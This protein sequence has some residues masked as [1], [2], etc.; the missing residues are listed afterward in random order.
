MLRTRARADRDGIAPAVRAAA[1][2]AATD[3]VDRALAALPTGAVV[4]LY[5][6]IRSE[7]AT[8]AIA[9]AAIARGLVLAYPRV[10]DGDRHLV[11]HRAAAADLAPGHFRI[12]EPDPGA[13][14]VDAAALAAIVVPALL[15][16]RR[17]HRLGWGRGYYDATLPMAP[18]ALR[19]GLGFEQQLV[20]RLPIHAHDCPV[21][22][23]ATEVALHPGAPLGVARKGPTT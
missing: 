21:H 2:A 7:L 8:D 9:Q 18:T 11:F 4:A 13:P 23:I 10:V 1:T 5:A 19:I 6:A 12:P 20:D 14:I 15:F 3:H 22:L 16:D 17:G